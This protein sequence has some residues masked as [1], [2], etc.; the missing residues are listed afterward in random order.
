MEER[1][2]QPSTDSDA[3][4]SAETA[5]SAE[6]AGR[7]PLVAGKDG[8]N[9]HAEEPAEVDQHEL[10]S[11]LEALLFVSSEPIGIERL[12][13]AVDGASK[14]EVKKALAH[15]RESLDRGGRAVQLVEVAGGYQLRTRGEYGVW[16]KRLEKIKGAP[17]LSRSALESLAIIAYKQPLTRAEVEHIR[18][19]ETSGV[20]RTLLERRLVRIVGRK[21]VPGRPIL[22]GTTR[23]FLQQFG[24]NALSDLPPLREFKELGQSEQSL[25]PIEHEPLVIGEGNEGD[26]AVDPPEGLVWPDGLPQ[27]AMPVPS[28]THEPA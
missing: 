22:Y 23:Q 9:Q 17:K 26:E 4:V 16:I 6:D 27:E 19:V 11:I 10:A 7:E 20:L 5:S 13:G 12:T 8:R 18:G 21:E 2:E 3:T 24:L 28:S 14:A 15:L 25:L 1:T